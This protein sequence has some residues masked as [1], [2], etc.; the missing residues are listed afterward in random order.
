MLN[1]S[2]ESG[3]E[4]LIEEQ[5]YSNE[6]DMDENEGTNDDEKLSDNSVK[7]NWQRMTEEECELSI[8]KNPINLHVRFRLA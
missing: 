6:E 7:D 1:I 2:I 5:N 4:N 8:E 3:Q